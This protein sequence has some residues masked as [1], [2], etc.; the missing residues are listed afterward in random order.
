MEWTLGRISTHRLTLTALKINHLEAE[1]LVN[2]GG[3][4]FRNRHMSFTLE[5]QTKK[6]EGGVGGGGGEVEEGRGRGRGEGWF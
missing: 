4:W 1:M 5:L 2:Q 3:G 6:E